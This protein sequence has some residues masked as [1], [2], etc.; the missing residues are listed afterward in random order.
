LALLIAAIGH[1]IGIFGW[2]DG[3]ITLAFSKTFAETGRL[4][5]T[6]VSEQ[7]EGF[8]S[9]AWFAVNAVVALFRPS[10]E[11]AI[12]WSQIA[13]GA[14]IA[15]AVVFVWLIARKL[16]LRGDTTF[17]LLV[18]L[19]LFGPT[20]SEIANGMEMGLFAASA[21]ALI[22]WLY[23]SPRIGLA[24]AAAAVF[25]AC[26]FE[27]MVW[28]AMMMVPLLLQRRYKLFFGMALAGLAVTGLLEAV[29]FVAFHDWLPNTIYAKTNPPYR[30]PNT[31][32][33]VT[34]LHGTVDA[35]TGLFYFLAACCIAFV[36][37]RKARADLWAALRRP[38]NVPDAVIVLLA[39]VVAAIVLSTLI[40]LN[41]G[42]PG[43]M[44]FP[45]LPC[46][47]LLSGLIFDRYLAP[48]LTGS[49][50]RIVLSLSAIAIILVSLPLS[51][52]LPIRVARAQVRVDREEL[53][54]A[55]EVNPASYRRTALAVERVRQL[56]G[57]NTITFMT[58]DVGGVGLCCSRQ[59]VVDLGL[60][61]NRQLGHEGYAAFPEVFRRERPDVVEVHSVWGVFSKIYALPDFVAGYQPALIDDTRFFVRDDLARRLQRA[62]RVQICGAET[63]PCRSR[64][65]VP[66]RYAAQADPG[67][68]AAFA[69]R[70]TVLLID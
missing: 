37:S 44:Q 40:G 43:R 23:F 42:Y 1:W 32:R 59:R 28:F 19:V 48:R 47:L 16:A 18:V 6:A 30:W 56:A 41:T 39:P 20:I 12:F 49:T 8:S 67:D 15:L 29:R 35:L 3:A 52:A 70:G 36:V 21:L 51:A 60:L 33:L 27:A 64:L 22:Y 57:M 5:L 14:A 62:P 25:L 2:D 54:H 4:A 58:P 38:W 17:A 7:V 24:V 13:T 45:A 68:D 69:R 31:S 65:Q 61:T 55:V 46:A 9:T 26:R 66:H 11:Q 50:A 10:F 53:V 63:E 34:Q